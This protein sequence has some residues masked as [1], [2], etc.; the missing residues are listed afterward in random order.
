LGGLVSSAR[1][2]LPADVHATMLADVTRNEEWAGYLLCGVVRDGENWT[3]LG[4]EWCPVPP[5]FQIRGTRYGL[6]WH[7]DFDVEMLNRSQNEGMACV[8]VHHHGG[9]TPRLSEPDRNTRDSLLPF[10]SSNSPLRPHGFVV[11]GDKALAGDAFLDGERIGDID[12]MRVS[13][14]WLEDWGNAPLASLSDTERK[15]LDRSIRAFG[16]RGQSLIKTSRVG[17]VGC[18]G[19]GSHLVQQLAYLG[20]G[21]FVLIDADRV[22]ETNLN[23]LIG[24][25]P[26]GRRKSFDRLFGRRR[27][28]VGRLKVEVMDRLVKIAN[29]AAEVTS[30]SE[31]FPSEKTVEA[32]RTCDVVV[33]CVDKLQVRDDLNRFAKRFVIPMVDIGI[34]IHADRPEVRGLNIAGRVTKVL[35]DGPCLRCQGIIDDQKIADER[36]GQ[37]PG[38]TGPDGIPDPA[39]VTLNGVVASIAATEVLQLLTGFASGA[40]PNAGWIYDGMTGALEGVRK[41]IVGCTACLA[42]RAAGQPVV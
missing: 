37:A 39:V 3:F 35:A 7:P 20:V 33:A 16:A 42:E 4:R 17:I 14:A 21:A 1:I 24:A 8:I 19:G 27:G 5:K 32:L 12:W 36:G 26:A 22:E 6:T 11:L 15:R 30:F 40:G 9:R 28:D 23:R 31:F 38:Y 2:R 34:Q 18:G 29:P 41:S 25:A 13:G 10:L